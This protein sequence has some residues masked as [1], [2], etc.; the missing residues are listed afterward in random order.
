VQSHTYA[1]AG[2]V[3]VTVEITDSNGK[4]STKVLSVTVTP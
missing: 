4:T 2:T 1:A 3:T